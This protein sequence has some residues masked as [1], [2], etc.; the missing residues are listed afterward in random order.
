MALYGPRSST[1]EKKTYW[2]TDPTLTGR[3]MLPIVTVVVP[4][5]PDE[6]LPA[7]LSL[8]KEMFIC[9]K[10]GNCNRSAA[11]PG[12]NSTLCTSKS[13][14]HKV[15]TSA[16]WCGVTTLDGLIGGKGIGSSIGRISLL[17]SGTWMVF[18]RA[19]TVAARN[20]LFFYDTNCQPGR[21]ACSLWWAEVQAGALCWPLF[22]QPQGRPQ[23]CGPSPEHIF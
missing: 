22:F 2:T 17:L 16:S 5:K 14:I 15:S 4:L 13:L 19:W 3:A 7:E 9:L 11:L 18:T 21:P 12:S 23:L 6:I 1:T 10:A 20:S 8:S